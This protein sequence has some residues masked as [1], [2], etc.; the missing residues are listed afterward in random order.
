M[1]RYGY[2]EVFKRVSWTSRYR[3]STVPYDRPFKGGDSCVDCILYGL[4]FHVF[5]RHIV[6]FSGSFLTL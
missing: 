2:L 6:L 5:R 1:S 3:E 4:V